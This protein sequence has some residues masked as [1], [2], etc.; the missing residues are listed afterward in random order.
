MGAKVGATAV[1]DS[2]EKRK[3]I[4][5]DRNKTVVPR[6]FGLWSRHYT[7]GVSLA[8]HL[9]TLIRH[10]TLNKTASLNEREVLLIVFAYTLIAFQ[11]HASC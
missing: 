1:L 10:L 11:I 6:S 4:V 9:L 3:S 5:I 8:S 7:D 2:S